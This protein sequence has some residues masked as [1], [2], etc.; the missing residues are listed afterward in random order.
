MGKQITYSIIL[1]SDC[2]TENLSEIQTP[3]TVKSVNLLKSNCFFSNI[4]TAIHRERENRLYSTNAGLRE[5]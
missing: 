1:R 3:N 2:L 5:N 4:F